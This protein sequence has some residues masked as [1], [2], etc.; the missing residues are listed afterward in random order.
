MIL[1]PLNPF[2]FILLVGGCRVATGPA[3]VADVAVT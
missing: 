1:E 3:V 2:G